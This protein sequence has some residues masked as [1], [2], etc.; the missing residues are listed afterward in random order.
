MISDVLKPNIKDLQTDVIDLLGQTSSLMGR[1]ITALSSDSASEKYGE[2]QQEVVEAARNVEKLELMMAIVAPMKAGKSTII[3]AI[4][5]QEILPSR[6]TAMTTL[7]TKIVFNADLTEPTLTLSA[8]I[9]S[10]FQETLLAL[11][12]KVQALGTERTQEKIA[13]YPHLVELLQEIQDTV[14]FPNRARTSGREEIIKALTGL[15]DIIRLC[16]LLTPSQDP[17]RQLIEVPFIETPFWR[18]Q[19]TDKHKILGN[20]VIVDTPGPNE[21]GENLKM[22]DVVAEQ[23]R[24]SSMVLIVLDFTQLKTEAAEK[25]KKDVQQVINL[26][27]K[28]NLYVLVNKV[29]QRRKVDM[30]PEQVCLFVAAEFGIGNDDTNRVFEVSAI[31]AFAA[32]NFMRELQQRPGVAITDLKTAEALAQEALGSRWEEKLEETS[33]EVLQSEAEY[34]WKKSG[35]APFLETAINTLM[36]EAAP[37]CMMSALK[38]ARGRLV[39]LHDNVQL[40][41]SAINEDEEKL[42][43]EFGALKDDLDRLEVCRNRLKEVDKIKAQLQQELNIILKQLKDKCNVSIENFFEEYQHASIQWKDYNGSGIIQFTSLREAEDFA[44]LAV[45]Y[46]KRRSDRLLQSIR[47]GVGKQIEQARKDLT[48]LLKRETKPIIERARDRLN[49]NFNISLSFQIPSLE[50]GKIGFAKPSVTSHI[51]SVD[52]GYEVKV[53]G[54]KEWWHWD[55][56]WHW[57]VPIKETIIVKKPEKQEIYYTVSVQE[58][59]DEVNKSIEQSIDNIQQGIN[60][61]LDDEFRERVDV[62]FYDLNRYLSNYCDSLKQAQKEQKLSLDQKASLMR[63]FNYLVSEATAQ[64]KKA[65]AYLEYTAQLIANNDD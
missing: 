60:Q 7:P 49:E 63:I 62:L 50:A 3:N 38:I 12:R 36:V 30:T 58:T 19:K 13:Q 40:R 16:S 20:L 8:E 64:I 34:L 32:A 6:N 42:R 28:E 39:E 11:Q 44:D 22:A 53:D 55:W 17:L 56:D 1:A 54:K 15:N 9:L 14:G 61:Y 52:Q 5:G 35:A 43:L 41:S 51:R 26:R 45:S 33:L 21:A 65:D 10:V 46:T 4:V 31:R 27:G 57:L 2:F 23:L 25:V 24:K 37:Q 59:V 29:D 47:T 18:S 48:E